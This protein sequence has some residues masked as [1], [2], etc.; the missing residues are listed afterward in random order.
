MREDLDG[1]FEPFAAALNEPP[2]VS[3]RLNPSKPLSSS[4]E[5]LP[6][7]SPVAWHPQ[8]YYLD[9]RPMFALDPAFHAGAYYVQEAS[10][11]ILH[12]ALTQLF[13]DKFPLRI[14]DLCAAPGGKSTLIASWMPEGSLLLSNEIIRSRVGALQG[15]LTSWGHPATFTCSY[16]PEDF[17]GLAGF[18]DVVLVDAPCSGE[19]LFRKD[20]AAR[21]EWSEE[22]VCLSAARQR[23]I[24]TAARQLVAPGGVLL[25]STCTY[26]DSENSEN[27][28][29]LAKSAGMHP[30]SLDFPADWGVVARQQGYQLYPHRVR[31]EGFYLAALRQLEGVRFQEKPVRYLKKLEALHTRDEKLVRGWLTEDLFLLRSKEGKVVAA[32]VSL[33]KP[34]RQLDSALPQGIWF[35]EIGHLKGSE[36]IPAHA[37]AMRAGSALEKVALEKADA[38]R[39]LKR[40]LTALPDVPRGWQV[41]TYQ[42][43]PL[44][45]VK[46]LGNRINN[47][48]P[49]EQRIRMDLERV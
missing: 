48:F 15:N 38:L 34:L 1:D 2:P 21:A 49:T 8:G 12:A 9:K 25:Y 16:D 11:M 32:P 27:V 6:L 47:Y 37:L 41:V 7:S 26:N 36:L 29:W 5:S 44:G 46:N 20:P 33:A 10:S 23:R 43:L 24:L 4:A 31:G 40:E 30:L 22:N 14:L 3:I 35:T 18:F 17:K 13:S 28:A 19:G 42:G 39:F 45:W